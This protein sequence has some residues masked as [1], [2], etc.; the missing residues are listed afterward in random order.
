MKITR[1]AGT[2]AALSMLLLTALPAL[3]ENLTGRQ[4]LDEVAER[5]ERPYELESQRMILIDRNDNREER[6][7]KRY[8]R[9]GDDDEY[10][11]LV[12]F[13]APS[14]IRG[15]SLLTWQQSQ[16]DDDQW[17]YMPAHGRQMRRIAKG[18]RRNYFMGTD[19]AF[20]DLVFE[21]REKFT[22]ERLADETIDG[23]TYYVV[24]STPQDE[25]LQKESGYKYRQLWI[26]QDI[27]FVTR[28]DYYDR[29]GRFLKRQTNEDIV[30]VEGKTWR[31][32]RSIMD[33]ESTKHQTVIEVRERDFAEDA[34]PARNFTRR[35]VTSGRH[36]R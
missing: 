31:A 24:K 27:F 25:E 10:K 8:V 29:R 2:V 18:G 20:E 12:V 19:Y 35:F 28:T 30:Q 7:V 22:Y 9:Q 4:I 3:A 13:H 11:Y 16:G 32:N 33:N 23:T 6:E 26:R 5:H 36:L 15:V 14:G 1:I 21:S 34:V 17:L